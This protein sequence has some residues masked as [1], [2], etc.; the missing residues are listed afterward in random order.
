MLRLLNVLSS[1]CC[2]L[3]SGRQG[4]LFIWHVYTMLVG[5]KV[6]ESCFKS[7]DLLDILLH[8]HISDFELF[9]VIYTGV[10]YVW[11]GWPFQQQ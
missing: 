8:G 4:A 7:F 5:Q 1:R 10:E 2:I 11:V 3:I 6:S 9:Y